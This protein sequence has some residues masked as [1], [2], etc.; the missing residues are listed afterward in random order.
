MESAVSIAESTMI[1]RSA[2][3]L[4]S[5]ASVSPSMRD[6][7]MSMMEQVGPAGLEAA[8]RLLA[9]ARGLDL[10]AVVAEL[11]RE[12]HEQVRIV[13]DE[14]DARRRPSAAPAAQHGRRIDGRQRTRWTGLP[15]R[16]TIQVVVSSRC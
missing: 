2:R 6:I 5:R 15:R 16:L 9:V 3:A 10:E 1:G 12:Q 4:T 8:E 11:V 7:I 14:E 13:V